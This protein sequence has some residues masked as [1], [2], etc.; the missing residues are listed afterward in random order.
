MAV[1]RFGIAAPRGIL[2][3]PQRVGLHRTYRCVIFPYDAVHVDFTLTK[4][5]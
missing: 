2:E 4:A 3:S 5:A 1:I